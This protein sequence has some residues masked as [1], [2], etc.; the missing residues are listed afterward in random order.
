MT[1]IQADIVSWSASRPTWQQTVLHEIATG[2]AIGET[3]LD[4]LVGEIIAASEKPGAKLEEKDL[5]VATS[6]AESVSLRAVTE[7]ENVNALVAHQVLSFAASGLTVIY[8]D[9][10]SG[11]SGFARPIK[12]AVTSLHEETVHGDVF[13]PEP[14]SPQKATIEYTS[15]TQDLD[16]SWPDSLAAEL[17]AI[18]FY[19][20][21]C[22]DTYLET[23]SELN[24]RP[25]ALLVLDQLIEIC[26]EL[27][28]R[29]ESQLLE[30]SAATV[31]L[32]VT[33]EGCSAAGFLAS[34]SGQTTD[35]ELDAAAKLGTDA[36]ELH[37]SLVA[38]EAR[39]RATD[40][41]KEKARLQ[42][43]AS[44][45]RAI[46]ARLSALSTA[47]DEEAL[48]GAKDS[49][50]SLK[51][52]R[53]ASRLASQSSFEGEPLSG[54]GSDS[55]LVLWNAARSYSETHA[56]PDRS[57]P[58]IEEANCVLCQ[59]PLTS[60]G[61]DRLASFDAFIKNDTAKKVE[62]AS[63]TLEAK[64]AALEAVGVAPASLAEQS[65]HLA[66]H[67]DKLASSV[68][69]WSEVADQR[70][71]AI[72]EVL[73]DA[74]P[75]PPI[76]ALGSSPGAALIQQADE[77]DAEAAKVDAAQF[78]LALAKVVADKHEIEGRKILA[79]NR[80]QVDAERQRRKQRDSL[81]EA[82]RRTVTTAISRKIGELA[83][84]YVTAGVRDRFSRESDRLGLERIELKKM[85]TQKGKIRH[86]PG[87][88]GATAAES[89]IDV[90]SEGEQTALGLAGYFT[91]AHFDASKS[92]LV[93]D[94]PVSSLD[95]IR[96]SK[97]AQRLAELG[98]ERQV[99]VFTHDL[100]FVVALSAAAAAAAVDFTERSIQ[101]SGDKAPGICVDEHPWK[102]K[103]VG[104]RLGVLESQ[105]AEI[106]RE[107]S[108]W[109]QDDYE[110]ACSDWAGKLSEAWERLLHLEVAQPIFD[111]NKSEVHPKGLRVIAQITPE[112]NKLFQESYGR[113]SGWL[114]RHDK[115]PSKNTVAPEPKDL[116]AELESIRDFQSQIKKYKT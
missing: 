76:E 48:K 72:I 69:A 56:Y 110:V 74:D 83:D 90:L 59:Q 84:T 55:W 104:R 49:K 16:C 108:G 41:A 11:K 43:L 67:D 2:V 100:E 113:A 9:N 26:D 95:H 6:A 65:L 86:I 50:Q 19:D 103:D 53:M 52:A 62:T 81:V 112:Q 4:A 47:V 18:K 75:E 68:K 91:E 14:D 71:L 36:E 34:L 107:R 39:L 77:L 98:G 25:S 70:R 109:T 22:G 3:R 115:S 12:A 111:L 64:I 94:D 93:L 54:V 27:G 63:A 85:S 44:E 15:G 99:I 80:K 8:G 35:A 42:T 13:S 89:V 87:L 88:L 5:P 78:K 40:P 105:L 20:E 102:A 114:R 61:A 32:P 10:A 17:A 23:E 1:S 37:A 73:K 92:A 24:Y 30:N 66:E 7:I 46:A 101:R 106:E 29:V 60:D 31:P 116:R 57:F 51:A 21:A 97:V 45:L 33:P 79:Q 28:G 82:K 58:V 38:E 96:R